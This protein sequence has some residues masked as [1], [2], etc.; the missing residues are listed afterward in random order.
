MNHPTKYLLQ[1]LSENI[2]NISNIDNTINYKIDPLN[3]PR[4]ILYK[5]IENVVNFK[6]VN[7]FKT[8]N[9]IDTVSITKLYFDTYNKIKFKETYLEE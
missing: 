1:F 5:C 8:N 3:D 7:D 6:I 9:F 2:I 4:C